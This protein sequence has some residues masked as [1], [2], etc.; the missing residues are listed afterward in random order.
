MPGLYAHGVAKVGE[1]VAK[2][3]GEP[4]L[5]MPW[6]HKNSKSTV[7]HYKDVVY[8]TGRSGGYKVAPAGLVWEAAGKPA[9]NLHPGKDG[10]YIAAASLYSRI[11]KKSA[12]TSSYKH[13]DK[14]ADLA[15]KVVAKNIVA[16]AVL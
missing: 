16:R 15:H 2:G 14:L 3:S 4:V 7:A 13:N 10:A 1:E 8:R 11:W 6:P 9:D 5:L 12:S